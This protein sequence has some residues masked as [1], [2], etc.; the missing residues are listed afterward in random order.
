L[1]AVYGPN[2]TVPAYKK[3]QVPD[4]NSTFTSALVF[5]KLAY[6]P[7]VE[8]SD[9][10]IPSNLGALKIG[11]KALQSEDTEEDESAEKDWERAYAIL[12]SEVTE[13]DTDAEMPMWR[14][15]SESGC[16]GIM[17]LI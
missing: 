9:I 12:N 11:L 13:T 7:V 4:W 15:Q 6:V 10:V 8:G 2:E 3:Y 16:E 5:G 14:V 17:T 1:I